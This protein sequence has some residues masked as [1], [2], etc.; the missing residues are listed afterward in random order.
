MKTPNIF[1]C[2]TRLAVLL[3]L[4]SSSLRAEI[5]A[6]FAVSRNGEP[7]GTFRVELFHEEVPRVCAN[8][9]GLASGDQPWL[10]PV[11]YRLREG[12]PFYDGLIFH[13]LTHNFV[14][15]GGDPLGTGGGGPGYVF[16]DQFHPDLRHDDRYYMSMAHAGPNTNGSQFFITLNPTPTLDFYH[17]VFGRVIEGTEIIDQFADPELFP[18]VNPGSEDHRPIDTITID[19]VTLSGSALA[20]FRADLHQHGLPRWQ[21][22]R[23]TA[24]AGLQG[25]PEYLRILLRWQRQAK[26]DYPVMGSADLQTWDRLGFVISM[27]DDADFEAE[28]SGIYPDDR[29]FYQV[30]AV[31]YSDALVTAPQSML[32]TGTTLELAIPGGTLTLYPQGEDQ[33]SWTFD[34]DGG[35]Q[36]SGNFDSENL[37]LYENTDSF[38]PL[39]V[40]GALLG[41]TGTLAQIGRAHV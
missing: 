20:D 33:G 4:L 35:G 3:L 19:S 10:D 36:L 17:S 39:P 6:D 1:Y 26:W 37:W 23:V 28:V 2:S 7:L 13:R 25:D 16:Q 40:S 12:T 21:P 38:Q 27:D 9:V 34:A 14:I 11:S 32:G 8:F 31:D 41:Q 18:T 15:Q 29:S 22:V 24:E 30:Y 5:F